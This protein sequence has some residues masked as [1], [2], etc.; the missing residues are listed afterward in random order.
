MLPS[1]WTGAFSKIR[2]TSSYAKPL[3]TLERDEAR[4]S[5]TTAAACHDFTSSLDPEPR[6]LAVQR[7]RVDA[8]D[9]GGAR[10]VAAFALKHPQDVGALDDIERGSRWRAL[11]DERLGSTLGHALGQRLH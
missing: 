6:Q 3:R 10:L 2:G 8:Q 1:A 5:P 11:R 9:V 4:A 7:R